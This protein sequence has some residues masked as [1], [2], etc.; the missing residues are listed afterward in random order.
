[1][2]YAVVMRFLH[3]SNRLKYAGIRRSD[4][5]KHDNNVVLLE[6]FPTMKLLSSII[7]ASLVA[8]TFHNTD[9]LD[10]S[11]D[12]T[13]FLDG[14]VRLDSGGSNSDNNNNIFDTHSTPLTRIVGGNV[15][16]KNRYPY[17]TAL[18][19]KLMKLELIT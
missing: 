4:I 2:N 13:G 12:K 17:F 16:S 9:A 3:L 15:A 6:G 7:A 1:M 14:V 10:V 5:T 11:T 8:T 18:F 19:V